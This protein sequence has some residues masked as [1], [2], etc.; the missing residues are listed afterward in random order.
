MAAQLLEDSLT[1]KHKSCRAR[2]EL[3]AMQFKAEL[4]NYYATEERTLQQIL[5]ILA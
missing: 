5:L 1:N 3:A 4:Y 2:F